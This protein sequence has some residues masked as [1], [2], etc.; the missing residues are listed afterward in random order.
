MPVGSIDMTYEAAMLLLD[1][2][3]QQKPLTDTQELVLRKS[4]EGYTYAQIAESSGYDDDYIRDVGFR[5]W[6]TLSQAL[7]ENVTKNNVKSVLRRRYSRLL[8]TESRSHKSVESPVSA[9]QHQDWGEAIDVSVFYGRTAELNLLQQW[10]VNDQCRLV[11]LLGMGG[12]GKTALSVKLAERVQ[13]NF[14]YVIWRSLRNAPPVVN[15]LREIILFVSQQQEVNL[16]ETTEAKICCLI[17]YL[18]RQRCLIVLDNVESIL[19]S[20]E[21]AGRYRSGYE[22]YGQLCRRVADESHQSCLVLTSREKPSGFTA[23]EG[24]TLPVRSLQLTGLEPAEAQK[25]FTDKGLVNSADECNQLIH[26]YSGNPLALK[27]AAT[28]IQTLFDGNITEFTQQGQVV[29]GDIWELLEQQFHRLSSHEKQVMYWLALKREW[30]TL[31][32][33]QEDIIPKI[34]ERELLEALLSLRGRS[35]IERLSG[36][37]TQQTVVMEYMIKKL[38]DQVC[39]EL[40]TGNIQ[41]FNSYALICATAK[42]YVRESQIRVIVQPILSRLKISLRTQ[43][44]IKQKLDN[45]IVKLREKSA[46]IPGYAS[47]NTI[48]LLRQLQVDFTGYDFSNLTIWQADLQGANLPQ[49]NF[50]NAEFN[51]STFSEA[52]VNILWVEFSPDGKFLATS[53]ANGGVRLWNV[54]NLQ[55]LQSFEGHLGWVWAVTFTKDGKT[56]ASCCDDGTVKVW[57]VSTGDCLHTLQEDAVRGWSVNFSPDGTLLA[58]NRADHTVK[59]WDVNSG[60]CLKTL[61]GHTNIVRPVAFSPDGAILATGSDDNT[62]K[63]WDISTGECLYTLSEHTQGVWSVTFSPDGKTLASGSQDKT[64]KL[65]DVATGK[66]WRTLQ[67]KQIEFVWSV[68]FSPNGHNLAIASEL[69]SISLWDINTGQCIQTLFGHS[70]R[71]WSVDFSP[72]SQILASAAEDQSVKLW[73]ISTGQCIKTLQGYPTFVYSVAFSSNGQLLASNTGNIIRIWDIAT[74]KCRKHLHGHTREVMALVFSTDGQTLFSGSCDQTIRIWDVNTGQC[75]RTLPGHTS[76]VFSLTCSPDGQTLASGSADKT[77]KLW[78]V[79]TGQCL[80][81][82]EG[83]SNWVF[84]V[85]WSPDG[86]LLASSSDNSIYLWDVQ[87]GQPL[88]VVP[89]HQSWFGAIAFSPDGQ[90]LVGGG[91]ENTVNL[92]DVKTG[93]C[94]QN[95][96]GHTKTVTDVKFSP[97][98]NQLASV[99][100]DQTIKLWDSHTGECLNTI[101]GHTNWIW[102]VTF[103]PHGQ[104]LASGSQ[105]ETIRLWD[106]ATGK[107]LQTLRSP[108]PYEGM[109][110]KGVTGLT[111]TQKAT[112]HILGAVE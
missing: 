74:G 5:L 33:L 98:G 35:L 55:Q 92:W 87:T 3:L 66:C 104:I 105:D 44:A 100:H 23:R 81:T 17:K 72:D 70:G 67:G 79:K 75:L 19:Q 40:T 26:Y 10:I 7:G 12:M 49:V 13:G 24:K 41:L 18:R 52:L 73:Q 58:S 31:L 65:W 82:L 68:A 99:S 42:D 62:V 34:S 53:D 71:V 61:R 106:I 110:I 94:Q 108:R 88:K 30:V 76:F 78:N 46:T 21:Q 43:A 95:L 97:Q 47:G 101:V 54:D 25:I 93:K 6:Q 102:A 38:I 96:H 29:I 77:I 48:N 27:I 20:G 2:V 103:H 57:D 1:T 11:A 84:S 89:G 107:C 83:N 51:K 85:A 112:L 90:K 63:L 80:K 8:K 36:S 56:L 9:Q 109:N 64:V 15:I 22:E 59:L 60:Q 14:D 28:T 111:A 37:Y 91:I 86:Q 4:W 45:V 32:E 39:E 69:P 50:T 16:P